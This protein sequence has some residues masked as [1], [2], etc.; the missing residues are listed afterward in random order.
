[1]LP[2]ALGLTLAL[3]RQL[4]PTI[5]RAAPHV[6]AMELG[7]GRSCAVAIAA[8]GEIAVFGSVAIQ[9]AHGDLLVGLEAPHMT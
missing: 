9:G 1:M 7:A 2:I 5:V 6:A 4:A 3:V 8:T